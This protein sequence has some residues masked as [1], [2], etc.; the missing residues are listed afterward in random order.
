MNL[1]GYTRRPMSGIEL[2]DKAR[3]L[4]AA[5]SRVK[6]TVADLVKLSGTSAETVRT[7]IARSKDLIEEDEMI[8]SGRR[9][10]QVK[11]YRLK[12]TARGRL[13]GQLE[14]LTEMLAPPPSE[15]ADTASAVAATLAAAESSIEYTRQSRSD[16]AGVD[17]FARAQ[18]ELEAASRLLP[19]VHDPL[20]RTRLGEK[21][22]ALKA[23][24]LGSQVEM[25]QVVMTGQRTPTFEIPVAIGRPPPTFG[26]RASLGEPVPI[27][28]VLPEE[29]EPTPLAAGE[30]LTLAAAALGFANLE[31]FARQVQRRSRS[32]VHFVGVNRGGYLLA[33]LLASRLDMDDEHLVRCDFRPSGHRLPSFD[34]EMAGAQAIIIIDDVVR[35]GH[36]LAAVKRVLQAAYR[37]AAVYTIALAAVISGSDNAASRGNIDYFAWI[38]PDPK[39]RLPWSKDD[40]ESD[41]DPDP[42]RF[43]D[44]TGVSQMVGRLVAHSKKIVREDWD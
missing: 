35:T 26:L 40:P 12:D 18:E 29:L 38:A 21:L 19:G 27:E 13:S 37:K 22:S 4:H 10:G 43:F 14:R 20:K 44:N 36:T 7:V 1:G 17:W 32:P 33:S 3:V 9:G 34:G 25:P 39:L 30:R 2:S 11:S 15:P 24:R 28:M 16:L 6:F 23:Q 31:F 42:T 5:L 41:P 8:P